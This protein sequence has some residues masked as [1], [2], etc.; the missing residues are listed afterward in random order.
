MDPDLAPVLSN[1][2]LNLQLA[3]Y[4]CLHQTIST[5]RPPCQAYAISPTRSFCKQYIWCLKHTG[6]LTTSSCCRLSLN[7]GRLR[8]G[9]LAAVVRSC[10]RLKSVAEDALYTLDRDR[11]NSSAVRWA[12]EHGNIATL[13]QASK[14]GL[15]IHEED[16]S[17]TPKYGPIQTAILHGQD[18][19]VAWFLDH[20]VDV[21]RPVS[22][23]CRCLIEKIGILHVA[24]CLGHVS[25]VQLLIS[26]GA[27]LEYS[28]YDFGDFPT[29]SALLEASLYGLDTIVET[30]VKDHGMTM[31]RARC[32]WQNDALAC[33]ARLDKNV[34]TVKTLVGLGADV[35][36]LHSEW[37]SSPLHMGIREGNFAI[38]HT[39][40]DLGA[41][42]RPFEYDSDVDI[43]SES[44]DDEE[45]MRTAIIKVD[46][47][48]LHDTIASIGDE[49]APR[50]WNRQSSPE[51]SSDGSYTMTER[52]CFM[53]RLI[54][55]GVDVNAELV[56]HWDADL[57][58][59]SSPLDVATAIGDTQDMAMLIAAGA[60]VKS[61]MLL[62]AW[63]DFDRDTRENTAK[64][65]LLLKHGARLDQP[66]KDG[67]SILEL[68]AGNV[69]LDEDVTGL[70]EILLLSSPK[71]LASDH[72]DEVLAQCL[73]EHNWHASTV[74]VRH[75]ARVSCQDKL[76]SIASDIA[77][78]LKC[79]TQADDLQDFGDPASRYSEFGPHDCF[80]FIIGMGLSSEDQCLIFQDLLRKRLLSLAHLF[81]DR[82]LASSPEAAVFL[83]A[84]LKLAASWGNICVIKRLWQHAHEASDPIICYLLVLQSIIA[85]NR[86]AVSFFMEQGATPFQ[87]LT[88]AQASRECQI[89]EEGLF[90]H[91]AALRRVNPPFTEAYSASAD[92]R[93]EY[94]RTRL[95]AERHCLA[96][97]A[98]IYFQP[99]LSPLQLAVKYGHIDI[100]GDLLEYITE[101][102]ADAITTC[103][104]IYI[105]CV[106]MQANEIREMIE[107]RGVDCGSN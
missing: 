1:A 76:F 92:V 68:A 105:P 50:E 90:V 10:R 53:R 100:I 41:K 46:M 12:A 86:E 64:I 91:A 61:R 32:H 106:L 83:P 74:L 49:R 78:D 16:L 3:S 42:V 94:R 93:R 30:L 80:S 88:A 99:F 72:T 6:E 11:Y 21:T 5:H 71:N 20:G 67:A 19:A 97:Y 15:V 13:D 54:E 95:L 29:T 8:R 65:E 75:G 25:T 62:L 9:D 60:E 58:D 45:R 103:G 82:G 66:I 22:P 27:P 33:A 59:R 35:N 24:I 2:S 101:S 38:A 63:Q 69:D 52:D 37:N 4:L 7:T 107:K 102:E 39:L 73:V 85:G 31:Q 36:G 84:Y 17:C 47:A 87:H 26:R 44:E 89:L 70:H 55:L 23:I 98:D 14:H 77:E 57:W 51:S 104:K 96:G 56:G 48:P 28:E 81:L 18:A 40:L 43:N 79:E 34:S